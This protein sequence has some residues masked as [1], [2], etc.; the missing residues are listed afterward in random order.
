MSTTRSQPRPT[1]TVSVHFD[2][3]TPPLATSPSS[4]LSAAKAAAAAAS[5]ARARA[6]AAGDSYTGSTALPLATGG[7][8]KTT[9]LFFV[10]FLAALA[11]SR[12]SFSSFS[13]C[14]FASVRYTSFCRKPGQISVGEHAQAPAYTQRRHVKAAWRTSAWDFSSSFKSS[15]CFFSASTIA[16]SFFIDSCS[17]LYLWSFFFFANSCSRTV[18]SSIAFW[19]RALSCA[20]DNDVLSTSSCSHNPGAFCWRHYRNSQPLAQPKRTMHGCISCTLIERYVPC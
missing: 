20:L 12:R 17:S 18:L 9:F 4:S 10:L 16:H 19:R 11:R 5:A 8:W 13:A 2:S 3:A 6:A 15:M 1:S 7:S 14:T